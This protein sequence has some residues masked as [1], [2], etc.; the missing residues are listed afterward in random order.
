M[1]LPP[2]VGGRLERSNGQRAKRPVPPTAVFF[3]LLVSLCAPLGRLLAL[4]GDGEKGKPKNSRQ[5][6]WYPL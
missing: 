4:I 3:F 1:P 6:W 2:P 5:A